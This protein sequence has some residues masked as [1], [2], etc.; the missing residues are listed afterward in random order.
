M[1]RKRF[2]LEY[3]QIQVFCPAHFFNV[4]ASVD[5]SCL[6]DIAASS[7]GQQ[8]T[9]A[10]H[11]PIHPD[12]IKLLNWQNEQLKLLQEQ[13]GGFSMNSFVIHSLSHGGNGFYI[14]I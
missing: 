9:S 14:F 10:D 4:N 8:E 1:S 3:D 7:S 11:S 6:G 13:V 2:E 5:I 12:V